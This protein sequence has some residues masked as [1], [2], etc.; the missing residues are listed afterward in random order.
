MIAELQKVFGTSVTSAELTQ[1]NKTYLERAWAG[2]L[3]KIKRGVWDLSQTASN[4]NN[5]APK[6]AKAPRVMQAQVTQPRKVDAKMIKKRF[7]VMGTLAD[8][9]VDCNIRAL[10]VAGSAGVGKTHELERKLE[11]G[12]RDDKITSYEAIK[13]SISAVG[14]YQALWNNQEKGNVLLLDDT[15]AVFSD[16]EALNLLKAALD[17]SPKRRISWAKA[18]RFLKD[19]GIPTSFDYEGQIVF[20]TNT[21]PEAVIEKGTK[22]APHMA[23]LLSRAVFLDLCIHDA[24][25]ILIRIEQV[26]E[27]SDLLDTLKLS[28]KDAK[29]IMKWMKDNVSNLRSISIR[30][31]IQLA[32]FI[33]TTDN[34][35]DIAQITLLKS[36]L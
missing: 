34:W 20:I 31:V 25:S 4:D 10:I 1:Y 3:R 9:V 24:E 22:M 5:V 17:T 36:N 29:Q 19:E 13:G 15:D 18:S 2:E 33:K 28:D 30:T 23:A 21:D 12:V 26:M 16:E 6:S 35:E 14:L 11:A 7:E 27:E 8:G 32:G